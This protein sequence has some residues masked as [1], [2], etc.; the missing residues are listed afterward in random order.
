MKIIIFSLSLYLSVLTSFAQVMTVEEARKIYSETMNDK[1]ACEAAYKKFVQ[2]TSFDNVLLK[3]Y[4]G[5]VTVA[6]SKHVKIIK[7]KIT[8]FNDGKKLIENAITEDDKNV[9]LK[10]IRFTIQSNCPPALK[11]NK[12]IQSDK[13]Y[14]IENLT[15]VKNAS[16]RSR[17][18]EYL[19]Q[20]KDVSEVEKQKINAL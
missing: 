2:I 4:K 13:K 9:E 1:A 16:V 8:Y 11:Y 17:I 3:G 20:S 10:F 15:G 14:I 18:K 6:M 7:E 5:A 19:L 12:N